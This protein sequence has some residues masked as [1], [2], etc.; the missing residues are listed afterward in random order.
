MIFRDFQT[1]KKHLKRVFEDIDK[2]CTAKRQLYNLRQ[3]IFA[4]TYSINFQHIAMNIKWDDAILI[5]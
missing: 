1:F 2:K 5:S 4:A 3:K